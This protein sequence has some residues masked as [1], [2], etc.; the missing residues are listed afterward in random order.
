MSVAS[1]NLGPGADMSRRILIVEDEWLIAE[2]LRSDLEERGVVILGP[3][4]S[5][6]DAM[7]ILDDHKPDLV[8]LDTQLQDGTC[9][10]VLAK[11]EALGVAV[12]MFTGHL[13]QNLPAFAK[14]R[15]SLAKPYSSQDLDLLLVDLSAT[16]PT[17]SGGP[18][19][20]R[21]EI[22]AATTPTPRRR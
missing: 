18:G 3:A 22:P 8:L 12:V 5:C 19:T 21:L 10:P 7:A 4:M 9:E 15:T 11:C 1:S 14:G 13:E 6:S 2:N 20:P 16:Q 17:S